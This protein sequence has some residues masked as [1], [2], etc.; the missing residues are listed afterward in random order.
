[1]A[2]QTYATV[3]NTAAVELIAENPLRIGVIFQNNS[4][5]EIV[6]IYQLDKTTSYRATIYLYPHS[7]IKLEK[8]DEPHKRWHGKTMVTLGTAYLAVIEFFKEE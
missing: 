6:N 4:D 1:L 2:K 8:E 3:T 5:S 7:Y